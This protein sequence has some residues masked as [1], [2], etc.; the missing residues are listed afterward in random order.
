MK[1]IEQSP[2]LNTLA[3]TGAVAGGVA[4]AAEAAT[5]PARSASYDQVA[6]GIPKA[7]QSGSVIKLES[8]APFM[9]RQSTESP[10][11]STAGETGE[12]TSSSDVIERD[13]RLREKCKGTS[14]NVSPGAVGHKKG[15]NY[16]LPNK[17]RPKIHATATKEQD[18]NYLYRFRLF[19]NVKYCH[20]IVYKK[21]R[22]IDFS[23][24]PTK[25]GNNTYILKDKSTTAD[26]KFLMVSM[27]TSNIK[28]KK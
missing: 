5:D 28:P 24:N 14:A 26:T 27:L 19:K 16:W 25:V 13:T 1:F 17:K 21:D 9:S 10:A 20:T 11:A 3:L 7:L 12:T 8:L 6:E 22:S 23:H 18:G 2:V 4:V 15:T